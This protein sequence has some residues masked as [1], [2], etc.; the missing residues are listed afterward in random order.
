MG[1]AEE[2]SHLK[3][4]GRKP[5]RVPET[6][7]GSWLH[8]YVCTCTCIFTN[9]VILLHFAGKVL[10]LPDLNFRGSVLHSLL[11]SPLQMMY[12]VCWMVH[13]QMCHGHALM[14]FA[15]LCHVYTH[16][17]QCKTIVLCV[18]VCVCVCV[19]AEEVGHDIISHDSH[20]STT[21]RNADSATYSP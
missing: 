20:M 15:Y 14:G 11:V 4:Y 9:Y 19:C 13:A 8:Y 1:P 2:S 17:L 10:T 21:P 6:F 18:C 7:L 12:T 5:R 16:V 3:N